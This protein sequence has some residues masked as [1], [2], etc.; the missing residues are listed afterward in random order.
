MNEHTEQSGKGAGNPPALGSVGSAVAR[1][2]ALIRESIGVLG[3]G[4]AEDLEKYAAAIIAD[5]GRA[6]GNEPLR[7][8]LAA[9][10]LL[11]AERMRIRLSKAEHSLVQGLLA[12][13]VDVGDI[14]I[15]TAT[16]GLAGGI[17]AIADKIRE[18]TDIQ[19]PL[20]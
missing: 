5:A 7:R 20:L 12:V 18:A 14:A 9:Q 13:L 2:E 17:G 6:V 15:G 19:E 8:E 16:G 3:R 1:L 10:S 4:T 11:L